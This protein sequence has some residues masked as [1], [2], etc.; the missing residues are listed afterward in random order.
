MERTFL[1]H[2]LATGVSGRITQ[3][4]QELLEVQ[5]ASALPSTGGYSASR[6]ENFRYKELLSFRSAVTLTTGTFSERKRTYNTLGTVTV[7]GLNIHGAITADRVVA[8]RLPAVRATAIEA[9]RRPRVPIEQAPHLADEGL[10]E[11][12]PSGD[13]V[14]AV[15][16]AR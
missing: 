7:E 11:P 15:G 3:P 1:Y 14:L 4:F 16:A 10:V 5:A 12:G 2:A 6:V 8:R 9:G 13:V